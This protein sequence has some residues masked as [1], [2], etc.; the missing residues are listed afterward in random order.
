[1]A[2]QD[3][4]DNGACNAFEFFSWFFLQPLILAGK[5]VKKICKLS[6]PMEKTMGHIPQLINPRN[7]SVWREMDA[8]DFKWAVVTL[9]QNRYGL[10]QLFEKLS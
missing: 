5:L 7:L 2:W 10:V 6:N 9:G 4:K 1:M 3:E 8:N